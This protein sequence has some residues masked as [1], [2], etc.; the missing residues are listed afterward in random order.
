MAS[1]LLISYAGF[2]YA[3]SSLFPDN[4]LASLAAT[5]RAEGHA[6]QILDYNT[7]GLMA[8]LVGPD[9]RARLE[10]VYPRLLQAVPDPEV[11]GELQRLSGELEARNAEVA[12]ELA[13][14]LAARCERER[15]DFVGFKL[16]SGDG[17]DASRRIAEQLRARVPRVRLFA[18]GPAVH[19]SQ[20]AVLDEAPVFDAVVDGDGE[21]AIL[22]LARFTEGRRALDG[23]P[24]LVRRGAPTDAVLPELGTLPIPEY[25]AEVYPGVASGEKLRLFCIDESRGCPMRCAFCI[26]RCIAGGHWRTRTVDQV[27]AQIR[28]FRALGSRAFRL[29]GTYSPPA[30]ARELCERLIAEGPGVRFGLSLH[31]SAASPELAALLRRAGCYGVFFGVE[32]G[33]DVILKS[34]HKSTTADRLSHAIRSSL[35]AGLFTVGSFIFP[36]PGETAS[37]EADTRR[38]IEQAFAG[39]PHSSI[40]V[41]MPFVLPRTT[42]WDERERFGFVL[43]VDDDVFRRI[44]VR[45]KIRHLLPASLW[46]PLPYALEHAAQPELARRAAALQSWARG[47]GIVVNLPEHDA[48]VGAGVGMDAQSISQALRRIF[49]LADSNAAE[50]LIEA[51]NQVFAP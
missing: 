15:I 43:T 45:Y 2:P 46:E 5:L 25:G 38:F 26:N 35:E 7:A 39:K 3:L 23:I 37:T 34:L 20:H 1:G 10:A 12:D 47:Q 19:Y 24:N 36:A 41:T 21:E 27:L 17:F 18:G 42:W 50:R 49:F 30:F 51:A 31:A 28:G 6:C 14:E 40:I 8:R 13:A 9:A 32:S 11:V 33:S 22:E 16:W 48:L 44:A 29:A 4:G